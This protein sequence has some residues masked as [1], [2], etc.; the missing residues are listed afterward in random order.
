MPAEHS[1][2]TDLDLQLRKTVLQTPSLQHLDSASLDSFLP[3]L[4]QE[5][6]MIAR[7]ARLNS[8]PGDRFGTTSIVHECYLKLKRQSTIDWV[9]RSQFI[10]IAAMAMRSILIDNAR[11]RHR[12]KRE[13]DHPHQ[14]I[15]ES[16]LVSERR[17]EEL[18]SLD[19]ALQKLA[20]DKQR[21]SDVI[22]CRVFG[23]MSLEDIAGQL[24]ISVAT[25]KR[26]WQAACLWLHDE[27]GGESI[28]S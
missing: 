9:N 2:E 14:R 3:E 4:Y 12:Q 18:L 28:V 22:I 25:V 8:K 16:L 15:D 10:H 21:W 11:R 26:D 24:Q 5:L 6:R 23:G 20:L 17:S 27:M 1:N 13:G 19:A 7:S